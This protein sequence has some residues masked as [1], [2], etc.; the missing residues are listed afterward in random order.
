MF[1]KVKFEEYSL[2][3]RNAE[4]KKNEIDY[5][6]QISEKYFDKFSE[7]I[8]RTQDISKIPNEDLERKI[9]NLVNETI[10]SLEKY[11]GTERKHV[12][13]GNPE[14]ISNPEVI[15]GWVNTDKLND[16]G[17]NTYSLF[18]SKEGFEILDELNEIRGN[19]T[20]KELIIKTAEAISKLSGPY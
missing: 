12:F 13:Y 1:K 8:K 4:I 18:P 10:N 20:Q 17:R 6:S 15:I 11:Q 9:F 7:L 3:E 16:L 14:K 19:P 5:I 2:I